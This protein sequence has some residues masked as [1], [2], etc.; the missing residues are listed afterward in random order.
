MDL[1][2]ELMSRRLDCGPTD[3][4]K[5]MMPLCVKFSPAFEIGPSRHVC[6]DNGCY[7]VCFP[8]IL[9][10]FLMFGIHAIQPLCDDLLY[11][12]QSHAN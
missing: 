5:I 1:W 2:N 11:Y 12:T 8:Y 3:H 4:A 6:I 7:T 10:I 9:N